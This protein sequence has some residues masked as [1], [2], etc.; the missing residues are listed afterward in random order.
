M[1]W[2][3]LYTLRRW[4]KAKSGDSSELRKLMEEGNTSAP[5]CKII[6]IEEELIENRQLH[7]LGTEME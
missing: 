5:N 7:I 4:L 6:L 3:A 1:K 2:H